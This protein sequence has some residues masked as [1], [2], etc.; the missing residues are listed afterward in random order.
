MVSINK[1]DNKKMELKLSSHEEALSF[2]SLVDGYFRLTA[3]AHHY[4]CTD[5]APVDRP[6]HTEWLSWSNLYRIRHQ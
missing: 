2:V 4:L 3:D 5:V 1:Q 6:Q